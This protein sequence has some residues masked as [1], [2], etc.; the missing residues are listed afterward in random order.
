M[1]SKAKKYAPQV[2]F[3]G[4]EGGSGVTDIAPSS[5][6]NLGAKFSETPFPYFTTYSIYSAISRS[7]L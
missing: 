2:H 3:S 1:A 6:G 7:W 5:L 4:G